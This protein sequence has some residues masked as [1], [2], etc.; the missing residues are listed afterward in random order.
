[1]SL[2]DLLSGF[3]LVLIS[4]FGAGIFAQLIKIA[5]RLRTERWHSKFLD[6][7]G[8]MPSAHTAF[9]FGLMTS[10]FISEGVSSVSFG[11]AALMA[12]IMIRDAVGF[13]MILEEHAQIIE[14]LGKKA[15]IDY[16]K[17]GTKHRYTIG[18]RVGHTMPEVAVGAIVGTLFGVAMWGIST[19]F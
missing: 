1:M 11:I 15:K 8:G 4:A 2:P 18:D 9:L 7:Y 14:A 3:P 6:G 16:K 13:R 5:L 10:V 12:A 19:L 17:I